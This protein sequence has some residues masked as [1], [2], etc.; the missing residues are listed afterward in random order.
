MSTAQDVTYDMSVGKSRWYLTL[1]DIVSERIRKVVKAHGAVNMLVPLLTPSGI[2]SQPD[3]I[4]SLMTRWGGVTTAP[5][6]LRLPFAR[7][8][9]HNPSLNHI[10]RYAIDRVYRERRVLGLHP[11]ELYECA[12][13]IVTS[14]PGNNFIL[15]L[16]H[17]PVLS[18]L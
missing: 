10:K 5:H 17:M 9:A 4:V 15:L 1:L 2:I 12:F 14:T 8:L 16:R 18:S 13:D 11:R 7:L 6:D 3:S